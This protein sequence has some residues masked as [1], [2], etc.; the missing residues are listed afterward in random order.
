MKKITVIPLVVSIIGFIDS[1]YLTYVKFANIPIYCTPGL[2]D[3]ATVQSSRW[4]TM[5]GIPLALL[6][7]LTYL[8]LIIFYLVENKPWQISKFTPFTI[9]GVSLFGFLFSIYLTWLEFFVIHAV[10]QWCI[11]SAICMTTIFITTL[12]RLRRYFAIK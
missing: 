10:C 6:G 1:L 9:W 7:A 8:A 11:L 4:S 2:G 12:I 5:W 3:C